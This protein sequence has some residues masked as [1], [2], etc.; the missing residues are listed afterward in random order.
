MIAERGQVEV[1]L[2]IDRSQSLEGHANTNPPS[3]PAESR[4]GLLGD[5]LVYGF[6]RLNGR[7]VSRNIPDPSCP[8]VEVDS[9]VDEDP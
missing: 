2:L 1:T 8:I 5:F 4:F 6:K 3:P 9:I 7:L